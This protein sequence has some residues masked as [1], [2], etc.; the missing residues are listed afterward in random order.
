MPLFICLRIL[1]RLNCVII[2]RLFISIVFIIDFCKY[3]R[4]FEKQIPE[5]FTKLK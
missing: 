1:H 5:R 2:F 4:P 3:P